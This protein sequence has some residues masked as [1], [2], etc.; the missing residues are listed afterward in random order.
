MAC[1]CPGLRPEVLYGTSSG[2]ERSDVYSLGATL[3]HLLAGRSPFEQPG[4]DNGNLALMRRIQSDPPPPT[5]RRDVPDASSGCCARP[6]PRT[7]PGARRQRSIS[8]APCRRL[9]RSCA[10][11]SPRSSW[12]PTSRQPSGGL[13]ITTAKP[14]ASAASAPAAPAGRVRPATARP[15]GFSVGPPCAARPAAADTT[16]VRGVTRIEL[17]FARDA[18]TWAGPGRHRQ[19]PAE[20]P[21]ASTGVRPSTWP[22]GAAG[23]PSTAAPRLRPGPPAPSA[24]RPAQPWSSPRSA[25]RSYSPGTQAGSPRAA[26]EIRQRHSERAG[27]RRHRARSS[28]DRFRRRVPAP[29]GSGGPTPTPFRGCL[30][31]A[32]RQWR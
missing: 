25:W 32:A 31:L 10:C 17:E 24:S 20:V 13:R 14:R 3:W 8:S 12:P 30:P 23:P 7:L 1:R 26:R 15:P 28:H 27:P 9:N 2:D 6:W 29:C 21:E 22:T 4:G 16:R 5:Q 18:A 19:M 11:R